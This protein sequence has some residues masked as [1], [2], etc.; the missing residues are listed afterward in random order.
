MAEE[1]LAWLLTG[2]SDNRAQ[3]IARRQPAVL[4]NYR[5]VPVKFGDY[6]ALIP[7]GP[8]DQV[9]GYLIPL[10]S[11]SEQQKIDDFEGETYC[12]S[13]VSV[14]LSAH[15]KELEGQR[16]VP[17][18]AYIWTGDMD[19]IWQDREWSFSRFREDRLQDWL[20]LF[21]GMEMIG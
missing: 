1:L 19:A 20:D 9:D 12:R 7:G 5:R 21:D 16:Q 8:S 15:D 2:S 17:V 10:Q 18:Q 13:E 14:T 3:I 6:P 4:Y 11:L